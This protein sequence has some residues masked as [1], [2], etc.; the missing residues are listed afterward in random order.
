[1]V[2]FLERVRR[3]TK[4]ANVVLEIVDARFID[5]TRN[6]TLERELFAQGKKIILVANKADLVQKRRYKAGFPVVWV[7]SRT[8]RGSRK[9]REAIGIAAGSGKAKIAVVG[10]PNTGKSSVI[11]M[12][13][14]KKVARSSISAG[15]TRGEQLVKI[16]DNLALIDLPGIIP[17]DEMNETELALIAAKSPWQ[18][19]DVQSAAEKMIGIM[20]ANGTREIMGISI[21]DKEPED[22]LAEIAIAKKKLRRGGEA[23]IDSISKILLLAWQ[24]GKLA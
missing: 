5:L 23:D 12:L 10:Y 1:M 2:G 24:K 18:L 3:V 6:T 19:K 14:G 11:N 9:L 20:K 21:T 17:L 16:S 22:I 15:Y 4:S 7:S 13:R 8:R